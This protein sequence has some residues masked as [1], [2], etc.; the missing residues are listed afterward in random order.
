MASK[1]L[2][3]KIEAKKFR[4]S[5]TVEWMKEN[6]ASLTTIDSNISV[7]NKWLI[8]LDDLMDLLILKS[9]PEERLKLCN[10]ATQFSSNIREQLPKLKSGSESYETVQSAP[11]RPLGLNLECPIFSG[12]NSSDIFEFRSFLGRFEFCTSNLGKAD[13]MLLLKS[14]LGGQA[15]DLVSSLDITPENYDLALASLK[16]KYLNPSLIKN[17]IFEEIIPPSERIT[18]K[19]LKVFLERAKL[20]LTELDKS[21]GTDFF[22]DNSTSGAIMAH[23][24][25]NKF[26]NS[27]RR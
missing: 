12:S 23:I 5:S 13:R 21:F 17:R 4:I 18:R 27:V 20:D 24:L 7:I 1:D 2:F 14:K 25:F 9:P 19:E 8:E 26:P 16:D 11:I 22:V 15:F 6:G 3:A 10:D